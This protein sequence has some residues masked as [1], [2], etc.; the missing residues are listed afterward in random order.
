M[1]LT[2]IAFVCIILFLKNIND[3]IQILLIILSVL[4]FCYLGA[5]LLVLL[6]SIF[7]KK[8]VKLY[9][10]EIICRD[11]I[12]LSDSNL[13]QILV[14]NKFFEYKNEINDFPNDMEFL[15][16][17]VND[18]GA[19]ITDV[20]IKKAIPNESEFLTLDRKIRAMSLKI[21]KVSKVKV[22]R[23]RNIV[24]CVFVDNLTEDSFKQFISQFNFTFS[25]LLPVI[26]E[27]NTAKVY[28]LE[29]PINKSFAKGKALVD[30]QKFI[31]STMYKW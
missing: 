20:F 10:D 31:S 15:R 7:S 25:I 16:K 29:I 3:I 6:S 11:T 13:Y 24:L 9:R 26:I 2:I 14:S 1:I 23:Q 8:V 28:H 27:V 22:V 4:L 18:K 21:D 17:I 5:R 19:Y 30:L 12:I